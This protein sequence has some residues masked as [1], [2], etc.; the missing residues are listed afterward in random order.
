[1]VAAGKLP[2]VILPAIDRKLP[3]FAHA[4]PP[5]WSPFAPTS[6]TAALGW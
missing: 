2:K 4:V 6:V 5:I 1:M 3:V